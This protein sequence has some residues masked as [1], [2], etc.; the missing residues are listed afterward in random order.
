MT[1]V[2]ERE[3]ERER[4]G[5]GGGLGERERE[6]SVAVY[7][8]PRSLLIISG[9]ARYEWTHGIRARAT[10]VVGEETRERGER[11]SITARQVRLPPRPCTC[12]TPLS[13]SL[14]DSRRPAKP[15]ELHLSALEEVNV[16]Q[17]YEK[18]A[19]HF[20]Q[21]RRSAAWPAVGA[22]LEGLPPRRIVLDLGGGN[23]RHAYVASLAGH[24]GLNL[25]AAHAFCLISRSLHSLPSITASMLEIPLRSSTVDAI[26]CIA[27]LHHLSTAAHR[28]AAVSEMLRILTL[29]GR[30]I[31]YVW[32]KEQ[33]RFAD[34]DE[35]DVLVPWHSDGGRGGGEIHQRFYHLFLAGELEG[36]C[37]AAGKSCRIVDSF[38]ERANHVVIINKRTRE[39]ISNVISIN[40]NCLH[41]KS[42]RILTCCYYYIFNRNSSLNDFLFYIVN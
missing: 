22:F 32:A 6:R 17:V 31:I 26:T 25:D 29:G 37:V 38:M 16:R 5:E 27:A 35:Q 19:P 18:I 12:G 34:D 11:M 2:G 10:D 15:Q 1:K 20:S 41:P 7:L 23:G 28:A 39:I 40:W 8:P 30:A 3:R 36:L 9:E 42:K 33:P 13:L 14:C 21:T 4:E 24:W